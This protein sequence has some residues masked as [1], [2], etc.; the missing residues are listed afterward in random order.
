[1]NI[2]GDDF[3]DKAAGGVVIII[4]ADDVVA[5]H[6]VQWSVNIEARQHTYVHIRNGHVAR[7]RGFFFPFPIWFD[8]FRLKR[9][10]CRNWCAAL[11]IYMV[12]IF[13]Y[14][15]CLCTYA[16]LYVE[17]FVIQDHSYSEMHKNNKSARTQILFYENYI[18]LYWIIYDIYRVLFHKK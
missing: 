1:M 16:R 5:E 15:E 18:S 14:F 9:R 17:L 12:H 4:A 11:N 7:R 2:H 8:N 3:V 10:W 6:S 13:S